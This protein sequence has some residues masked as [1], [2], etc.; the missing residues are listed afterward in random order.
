MKKSVIN[1]IKKLSPS[2]LG[3]PTILISKTGYFAG[4]LSTATGSLDIHIKE[5]V[6]CTHDVCL[7]INTFYQ[8]YHENMQINSNQNKSIISLKHGIKLSV[9]NLPIAE[10]YNHNRFI[11][12]KENLQPKSTYLTT[13]NRQNLEDIL[14]V[15]NFVSGDDLRP[16]MSNI[17]LNKT[18]IVATDAHVLAYWQATEQSSLATNIFIPKEVVAFIKGFNPN[19][20]RVSVEL[21]TLVITDKDDVFAKYIFEFSNGVVLS[22]Q[23]SHAKYPNYK[24]VIIPKDQRKISF[25]IDRLRLQRVLETIKPFTDKVTSQMAIIIHKNKVAL[26]AYNYNTNQEISLMLDEFQFTGEEDYSIEFGVNINLLQK[27][28]KAERL[29]QILIELTT[30]TNRAITINNKFLLMPILLEKSIENHP[31]KSTNKKV[32]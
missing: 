5:P 31:F 11:N 3:E 22:Y 32:A 13:L 14:R 29:Q 20:I 28:V 21:E 23:V 19:Y 10:S 25:A 18:H 6:Q 30:Q 24:A 8:M 27:V 4:L 16:A 12:L 1:L 9:E 2:L 7:P 17:L 15:A 26:Y